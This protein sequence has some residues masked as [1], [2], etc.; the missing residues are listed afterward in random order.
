MPPAVSV[1]NHRLDVAKGILIVLVVLGHVLEAV[2]SWE[3]RTTRLPLTAIYM[4][5]MPAFVFLAGVTAKAANLA[6][7]LG[8]FAVLLLAFQGL[9]FV[10]VQLLGANRT[11]SLTAPFWILWFLLAMIWWF[12]LLPVVRR[13]PKTSVA[14][15]VLIASVSG[16]IEPVDYTLSL[17]RTLVFLPFFVI[18]A[19]YGKRLLAAV[20]RLPAAA[21][22]S[23]LAVAAAVWLLL[24]RLDID[25]AWLYGSEP[26]GRLD[27][28][29]LQGIAV[30]AGLLAAAGIATIGFLALV[31]D[32]TGVLAAVGR[33][34]LAVFVLHGFVVLSLRPYLQTLLDT[35]GSAGTL[36][37]CLLV[38]AATV[39]VFGLPFFDAA[40]RGLSQGTVELVSRPFTRRRAPE[41]ADSDGSRTSL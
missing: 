25:Q 22:A 9:Y 7:R 8:T 34:S 2:A 30:R 37:V 15:S 3:A 1:R 17:S 28:P 38:T 12:L 24:Y 13:F 36:A 33:R 6:K 29:D 14:V 39:A 23:C 19:V 11:F 21:K 27:T 4:F 5:H 31:P 16:V 20:P 32:R 41:P 40:I 35:A 18:G 26:F 10:A